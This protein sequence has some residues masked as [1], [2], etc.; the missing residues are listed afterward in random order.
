[1]PL[2]AADEWVFQQVGQ[3]AVYAGDLLRVL[4]FLP[5]AQDARQRTPAM[6]AGL[7]K[8]IW[9]LKDLLNAAKDVRSP[10]VAI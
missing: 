3:L 7:T 1:M 6:A 8:T 2:H 9:N 10:Q 5:F 4:Q